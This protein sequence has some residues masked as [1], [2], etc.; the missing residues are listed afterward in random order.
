MADA[1]APYNF[2]PLPEAINYTDQHKCL[3]NSLAT[4]HYTGEITIE[5]RNKTSLF[6]RGPIKK[7]ANGQWNSAEETRLRSEPF[8]DHDGKPVIPGSSFRGMIRTI[9]EIISYSKLT[10]VSDEKLF[11]RDIMFNDYKNAFISQEKEVNTGLN[12]GNHS[13]V[14]QRAKVYKSKVRAGFLK[15]STNGWQIE[16]CEYARVEHRLIKD[17]LNHFPCRIVGKAK[18]PDWAI[19]N[20][21]CYVQ[22]DKNDNDYFF[23][24]KFRKDRDGKSKLIHPDFYLRFKKVRN[25]LSKNRLNG[26]EKATL[27]ITGHMPNKHM[28]FCFLNERITGNVFDIS[29]EM[30]DKFNDDAQITQKQQEFFPKSKPDNNCRPEKGH[31][32]QNE[33]VFFL[34]LE[35]N[36][37]KIKFFGRAMMFRFPYPCSPAE[38]AGEHCLDEKLDFAQ[39]LFGMVSGEKGSNFSLKSRIHFGDLKCASTG[40]LENE[41]IPPILASPKPTTFQHYLE[42]S[43]QKADK[44]Y[45]RNSK[46]RG[47]KLY[48]HRNTE[49]CNTDKKDIEN[50]RKN[51]D[52]DTQHTIV[53][54][55][56]PE[57]LFKGK[58]RFF[59]LN[60]VELGCLLNSLL[61]PKGCCHKIGMAKPLGFGSLQIAN[62]TILELFDP[63]ENYSGWQSKPTR[64]ADSEVFIK[65]FEEYI[66]DFAHKH[67]VRI[68]RQLHGL[69]QIPRLN[70]L[71]AILNIG[72]KPDN[73]KTRYMR[74]EGGN[75]GVF[76]NE[77][78]FKFR[79]I[80]PR[81]S[82]VK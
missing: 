77:N 63:D 76:K 74:I 37:D 68:E 30:I 53:K 10:P 55:L 26:Y 69:K 49:D 6:I 12:N 11:Y 62:S 27:V 24:K 79:P 23:P 28:E 43:G 72:K 46:L 4:G 33:P 36:P 31:L 16:E 14:N 60:K 19:Q 41:V 25:G 73:Q 64:T 17:R 58:I 70:E 3:Q 40:R 71:F 21:I 65:A 35:N 59:N 29:D 18:I 2:V 51:H 7:K 82:K 75:K 48:W 50:L 44:K 78:E 39:M 57:T 81:P 34:T 45:T 8:L 42:Q 13:T 52:K 47:H 15:K 66:L 1:I 32:R 80:L 67:N 56:K 22:A 38:L 61:L 20:T 5:A 54:P 9:A